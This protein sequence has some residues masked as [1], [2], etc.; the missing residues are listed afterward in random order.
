MRRERNAR[1]NRYPITLLAAL[2]FVCLGAGLLLSKPPVIGVAERS[3]PDEGPAWTF[4][5]LGD[6]RFAEQPGALAKQ[7]AQKPD[8]VF[9]AGPAKLADAPAASA[10][11]LTF[12]PVADGSGSAADDVARFPHLPEDQLPGYGRSAYYVDYGAARFWFL[13]AQRLAAEP[14]KQLDWLK[15]TA[16]IDAKPHRIV[17]LAEEPVQPEVWSGLADSGADLV[18]I[19]ARAYA[20]T[21]AVTGPP[22]AG[23]TAFSAHAGWA[24]WTVS[25]GANAPALL[26]VTG[27]GSRLEAAATDSAGRAAGRLALDA[28]GLRYAAATQEQA[29]VSIGA[30]WRYRAGGP[31][32]RAAIPPELDVS[33]EEPIRGRFTLPRDDWRSPGF[34]DAG[35]SR[36]TAPFG[37]SPDDA[38]QRGIRTTIAAQAQSPTVYFRKTFVLDVDPATIS[39]WF[40]HVSF[41][42]GFVAYLNGSEIARDSIRDGLIDDR[43]LASPHEAGPY[44]TYPLAGR[45]DLLV[46]GVNTLAV[47]VHTSRPEAPRMRFDLSLSY[48]K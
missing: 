16:A 1:R 9:F 5:Y 41:E 20:P 21:A 4:A 45:R 33:G 38:G 22:Q 31:D 11:P 26:T 34:D 10:A 39:E 14:A 24:E 43:S 46:K 2:L 36:G 32:V 42:D 27:R 8:I 15:Q 7:L 25:S 17:L 29:P 37:R 3:A 23:Y 12:F 44:E 48:R 47:E 30:A 28:A 6:P 18:L 35:W 13:D 40:L 19:G